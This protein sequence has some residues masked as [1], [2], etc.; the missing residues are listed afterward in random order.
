MCLNRKGIPFSK[1]CPHL[2]SR[3]DHPSPSLLSRAG[4]KTKGINVWPRTEAWSAVLGCKL[5]VSFRCVYPQAT[6]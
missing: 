1:I 4:R 6:T 3:T 5:L 2:K